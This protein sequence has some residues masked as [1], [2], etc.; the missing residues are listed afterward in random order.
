MSD[1]VPPAAEG[2]SEAERL[3]RKEAKDALEL[4]T[5]AVESGF[6]TAEGLTVSADIMTTIK[7]AA[8]ALDK[9]PV[10]EALKNGPDEW[11]K[12]QAAYHQLAA[13][14]HPVT[15]DTL[16][17]T[18]TAGGGTIRWFSPETWMP[19]NLAAAQR[20]AR[21]LFVTTILFAAFIVFAGWMQRRY[22]PILDGEVDR[23]NTWLQ[24]MEGLLPF[25]YGGLGAC[26]F[27]L[28]S[29][30]SNIHARTFDV[31]RK[32]EYF[33]RILLGTVAGGTI[34]LFVNQVTT[35]EGETIQLSAAA[36]GFLAGYSTD[37]LFQTIERVINA[38]L[39]K[40]GIETVQ[41]AR[42]SPRP[43]GD[44]L[45]IG[46]TLKELTDRFDAATGNDKELYRTL[47]ERLRDKI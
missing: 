17:A 40:V 35:E 43:P 33:N 42:P 24:L 16:R 28:R 25:S 21:G 15:A 3:Y 11:I 5:Y 4:L 34:T 31:R 29:A 20:F 27:L 14:L 10:G 32:P 2:P 45:N 38:I 1:P 36:L 8:A 9:T 26:V 46:M 13:L 41:T 18:A 39:P 37:F 7:T 12:L 22:G 19:G 30:H 23:M 44:A 6:K 47:V